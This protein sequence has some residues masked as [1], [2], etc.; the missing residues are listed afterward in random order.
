MLNQ[1]GV[2][3][4]LTVL[5]LIV[6]ISI[7]VYMVQKQQIFKSKAASAPIVEALEIKD[8]EGKIVNCDS[9]TNPPTC[10]ISNP[11]ISIK[12]KD[13]NALIPVVTR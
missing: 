1:K 7:G 8:S 11:N 4:I 2:V 6:G 12:I 13:P 3:H 9:N 10:N 5:L